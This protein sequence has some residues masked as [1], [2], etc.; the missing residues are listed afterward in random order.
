MNIWTTEMEATALKKR[1]D[2]VPNKAE[3]ARDKKL[4][5]GASMLSQHLSGNRPISLEAAVIYAQAFNCSLEEISPRIAMQVATAAAL[6]TSKETIKEFSYPVKQMLKE[7]QSGHTDAYWDTVVKCW[8]GL[9]NDH[10]DVIAVMVNTLHSR[11]NPDIHGASNP[12]RRKTD[13]P[14]SF[15]TE[16]INH[17]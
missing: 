13:N 15:D 3:F 16:A 11:I 1:F 6:I 8:S 12:S 5:G 9:S 4:P 2:N 14:Q 10:K 7:A 17:K